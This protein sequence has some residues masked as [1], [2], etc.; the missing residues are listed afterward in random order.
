MTGT[1]K[2]RDINLSVRDVKVCDGRATNGY[3]KETV[4]EGERVV[5]VGFQSKLDS[6]RGVWRRVIG[7]TLCVRIYIDGI[8]TVECTNICAIYM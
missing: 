2:F 1:D 3:I 6:Q 7:D 8:L 5:R 4:G